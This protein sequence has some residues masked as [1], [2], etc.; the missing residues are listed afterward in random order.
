M[1]DS[2]F[3]IVGDTEYFKE[4]LVFV[5]GKTYDEA[6]KCL[7]RMLENPTENDKRLM[8]GHSN[9]RIQEVEAAECWWRNA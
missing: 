6:E 2:D 8:K 3:I 7:K 9:F 5:A 1:N 4:C